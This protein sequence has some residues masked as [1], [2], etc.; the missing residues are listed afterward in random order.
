MLWS[1]VLRSPVL[2]ASTKDSGTWNLVLRSPVLIAQY[3]APSTQESGTRSL[4][5]LLA[6]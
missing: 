4:V 6:P 1:R 3:S 2:G 5:A